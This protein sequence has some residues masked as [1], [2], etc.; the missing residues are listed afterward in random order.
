MADTIEA[1]SVA[2]RLSRIEMILE[3]L[4]KLVEGNGKVGLVD[5]MGTIEECFE[6][7]TRSNLPVRL[8]MLELSVNDHHRK[9][10]EQEAEEKEK[11]AMRLQDLREAEKQRKE[12]WGKVA[13]AVITMILANVGAIVIGLLK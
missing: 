6:Y 3:R 9:S 4:V 2:V 1:D 7:M 10:A 12:F 5:R 8:D 11:N 13:L